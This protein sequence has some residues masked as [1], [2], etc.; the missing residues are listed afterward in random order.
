VAIEGREFYDDAYFVKFFEGAKPIVDRRISESIG[1]VAAIV[2]GAW[3]KA[4]KPALPLDDSRPPAR[5]RR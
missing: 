5:I 3:E 1:G 4:G 2:A